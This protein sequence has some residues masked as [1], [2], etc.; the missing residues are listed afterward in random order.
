MVTD[1]V[2]SPSPTFLGGG[3][4]FLELLIDGFQGIGLL[5]VRIPEIFQPFLVGIVEFGGFGESQRGIGR[6]E[7]AV[8]PGLLREFDTA[9]PDGRT[10]SEK[11]SQS[12]SNQVVSTARDFSQ[13]GVLILTTLGWSVG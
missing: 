9:P 8:Y 2:H 11:D 10:G 1:Y 12:L 6:S 5:N 3:V 7:G 4:I 13:F